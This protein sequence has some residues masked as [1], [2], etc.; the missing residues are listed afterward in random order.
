MYF[1]QNTQGD[2]HTLTDL[3]EI[4]QEHKNISFQYKIF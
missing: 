4:H 1:L 2:A 3:L